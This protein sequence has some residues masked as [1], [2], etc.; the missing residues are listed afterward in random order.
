MRLAVIMLCLSSA[1]AFAESWSGTLVDSKCYESEK[2]NVN[3]TDTLT[4]VD[5]DGNQEI[6]YCSPRAKTKL[7]AV[8]P[9][10]G[11]FFKLDSA[12]NTEAA[13]L[14]RQGGKKSRFAVIVTGKL[15]GK[16]IKVDS[17]SIAG[18][19]TPPAR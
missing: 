12:G 3:P 19:A 13:G 10:D 5:R 6:R 1:L 11:Q 4:R 14:V 18:S 7:F 17:L 2:R 9:P 15:D 16:T 8:V